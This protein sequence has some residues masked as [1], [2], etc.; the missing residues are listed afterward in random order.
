MSRLNHPTNSS[1]KRRTQRLTLCPDQIY[2]RCIQYLLACILLL[3]GHDLFAQSSVNKIAAKH[4]DTAQMIENIIDQQLA[5][6]AQDNDFIKPL[7]LKDRGVPIRNP[8]AKLPPK[9]RA[10]FAQKGIDLAAMASWQARYIAGH[11]TG[12]FG[13]KI[14]NTDPHTV[15]VIG[16][17]TM[18]HE[19][20]YSRGPVVLSGDVHILNAIYSKSL[21]WFGSLARHEGPD[22]NIGLPQIISDPRWPDF[23]LGISPYTFTEELQAARQLGQA[24][25]HRQQLP[26]AP[27][28]T[29]DN[30]PNNASV[31]AP[32]ILPDLASGLAHENAQHARC[33]AYVSQAVRQRQTNRNNDC[34]LSGPRWHQD[35]VMLMQHCLQTAEPVSML[36]TVA[37][38]QQ[39]ARCFSQKTDPNNPKNQ[40]NLPQACY[41]PKRQFQAVKWI[42]HAYRYERQPRQPVVDG[43]ITHDYNQDKKPDYLFLEVHQNT[44]RLMFCFSHKN[45]YQRRSSDIR[46]AASGDANRAQ[47]YQLTQRGDQLHLKLHYFGHNEGSSWR[48]LAYQY[49]PV[50][51]GFAIVANQA[52]IKPVTVEQHPYPLGTPSTPRMISPR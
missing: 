38:A 44:A 34:G 48:R 2:Y 4:P 22:P 7:L 32:L 42:N 9:T 43:L 16:T 21:L 51:Q 28:K 35:E 41:D 20:I 18:T 3:S 33:K 27:Q 50:R 52:G 6:L 31:S 23:N 30:R 12:A 8:L 25:T 13:K 1:V 19:G 10:A 37:R 46:F 39:L 17:D 29:M 40:P 15:M 24:N 36:E 47:Q 11:F 26:T 5:L 14:I 49:Q 45:G